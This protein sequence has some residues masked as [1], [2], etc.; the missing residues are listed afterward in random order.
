MSQPEATEPRPR[1]GGRP[2]S[3]TVRLSI[4]TSALRLLET[5]SL[6]AI[7][8]EAIAR[9]AEVSK[10]TIYRWWNSKAS[11]AIDAFME[12]HIVKTPMRYDVHPAEALLAHWRSLAT[13]YAGWPGRL[14]AQILAEG[15]SDPDIMR[16][17]RQ[18]FYYS[19][20]AVVREVV[21][22]LNKTEQIPHGIN[23]EDLMDML[24][25][26]IYLRLM[27]GHAPID[28]TFIRDFP[29]NMFKLLGLE[30]DEQGRILSA[31]A[32]AK[33]EKRG[34]SRASRD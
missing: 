18:R 31:T 13:Q 33:I 16:E 2:R 15:Q 34:R 17:F 28:E 25:A 3:E 23:A 29:L 27:W 8:I 12:N 30:F 20:R 24:Y 9:E 10:A 21:E 32:D 11:V 19:R 14:V 26:S 22:Q 5:E 6:Q 7:S 1:G 4:L